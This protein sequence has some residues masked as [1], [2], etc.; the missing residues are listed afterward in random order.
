MKAGDRIIKNEG[1]ELKD[2]CL[3]ECDAMLSDIYLQDIS[4]L[5]NRGILDKNKDEVNDLTF[6]CV[7]CDKKQTRRERVCLIMW[8]KT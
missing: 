5:L 2:C 1:D 7:D 8:H 6:K 3:L 4:F